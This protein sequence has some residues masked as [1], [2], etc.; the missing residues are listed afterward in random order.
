MTNTIYLY[1]SESTVTT[2]SDNE[3]DHGVEWST[4]LDESAHTHVL[5]DVFITDDASYVDPQELEDMLISLSLEQGMN[6]LQTS[7]DTLNSV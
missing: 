2:D 4:S 1:H 3:Y 5:G 7:H 6:P